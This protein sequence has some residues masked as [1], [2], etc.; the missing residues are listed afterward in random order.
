MDSFTVT[1]SR[2]RQ[3]SGSTRDFRFVRDDH[4]EC[5][6]LPGQFYRFVFE[7]SEGEFERSYSLCNFEADTNPSVLDLVIST[8]TDGRASKL[9]FAAEPGL[10]A[11]VT[12]PFGR[13]ILPEV[14]PERLFLVATSVGIAPYMPMLAAMQS[15]RDRGPCDVHLIYGVRDYSE[16]VYGGYLDDLDSS[17]ADFHLHLC[18]SRSAAAPHDTRSQFEGYVQDKLLELK[19]NP[20]TDHVLL[21][22]NPN[23]IDQAYPQLKDLGFKVKQVVRE[24]Y[25]FAKDKVKVASKPEMSDAQKKLLAEKMQRYQK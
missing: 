15:I 6:F 7:D 3:L 22:G 16:F 19:P 17:C 25:V 5:E 21:C 18:L 10:K 4:R 20:A 23:M 24:K 11:K 14:L 1:L 2:V 9:L 8:V 13:L 12:G